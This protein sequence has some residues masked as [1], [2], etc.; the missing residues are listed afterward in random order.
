MAVYDP[1]TAYAFP[2]LLKDPRLAVR[3]VSR[4][5]VA[6][7]VLRLLRRSRPIL[8]RIVDAF[9][10]PA[11]AR[12]EAEVALI[13]RIAWLDRLSRRHMTLGERPQMVRVLLYGGLSLIP[14]RLAPLVAAGM[15]SWITTEA[16]AHRWGL[17]VSKIVAVRQG[18]AGNPTTEMDLALWDLSQQ[19]KDHPEAWHSFA[20]ETPEMVGA[21]YRAG[22]L[23]E[24]IQAAM[25][26]FFERYGHRGIRE[27]DG[28]MPRWSDAPEYTSRQAARGVYPR[29]RTAAPS[30]HFDQ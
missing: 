6:K 12:R 17:D 29:A 23:P 22:T 18:L 7:A 27:I 21:A 25:R 15:L 20:E 19:I 24:P 2:E 8:R 11:K 9:R 3:S 1:T 14:V 13:E 26:A 10:H 4:R 16:L 5:A 30:P 28:G